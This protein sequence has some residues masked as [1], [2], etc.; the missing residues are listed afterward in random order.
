MLTNGQAVGLLNKLTAWYFN[1]DIEKIA[2]RDALPI[3]KM[4]QSM[5]AETWTK[6]MTDALIAFSEGLEDQIEPDNRRASYDA[7]VDIVGPEAFEAISFLIG[8]AATQLPLPKTA[9]TC[10]QCSGY[11]YGHGPGGIF[12]Q[13]LSTS[14]EMYK[15]EHAKDLPKQ[16]REKYEEE[17]LYNIEEGG[18][19]SATPKMTQETGYHGPCPACEGLGFVEDDEFGEEASIEELQREKDLEKDI[20]D[21]LNE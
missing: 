11:G 19:P 13:D 9:V 10:P 12:T 16:H 15:P 14:E 8:T 20:R 1:N 18:D 6:L 5:S 4:S 2:R 21:F 7:A 17:S 3:I